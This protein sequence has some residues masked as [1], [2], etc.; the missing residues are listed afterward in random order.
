MWVFFFSFEELFND[1]IKTNFYF[2][3]MCNTVVI[4]LKDLHYV[5]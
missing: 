3:I 4:V 5:T 2:E 1:I